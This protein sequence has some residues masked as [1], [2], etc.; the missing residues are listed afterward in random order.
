[1]LK[2]PITR[3]MALTTALIPDAAAPPSVSP[4]R[5]FA[6]DSPSGPSN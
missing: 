2:N 3:W 4:N 1:V 6:S 5:H